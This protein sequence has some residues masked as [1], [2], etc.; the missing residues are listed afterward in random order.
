MLI[1]KNTH[2]VVAGE[3]VS[4]LGWAYGVD[5]GLREGLE[6]LGKGQLDEQGGG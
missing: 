3:A 2:T 6:G 5:E 4:V 1:I